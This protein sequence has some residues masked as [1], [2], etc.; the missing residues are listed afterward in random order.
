MLSPLEVLK[1]YPEHDYTLAGAFESRAQRDPQRPFIVFGG[2]TWSWAEFGAAVDRT[3]RL[4]VARGVKKGDRIGVWRA[5]ISATSCCCSRAPASARSWCRPIPNSA[6]RRRA[7]YSSM[8]AYRQ[9]LATK[10]CCRWRARRARKSS[11]RRGSSCSTGGAPTR[12]T[13]SRRSSARRRRS[14][15][16]GPAPTTPCSSFIPRARPDF[17]RGRCTASATSSPGAKPTF[18]AYGCSRTSA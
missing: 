8:R 10:T 13:F 11:Q 7:S 6:L 4:L 9:S 1:L 16:C 14:C 3:A 5:T 17:P 2:K 18:R 15:R 12:R